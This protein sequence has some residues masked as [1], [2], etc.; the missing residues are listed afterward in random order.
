MKA[1]LFIFTARKGKPEFAELS[2]IRFR[3]HLTDHEGK[4]YEIRLRET[5]R[6]LQQ[7]RYYWLYLEII[8]SE[9]GHTADELHEYFR[10]TLLPPK[11]I[12]VMGKDIRLP[13]STTELSKHEMGEYLERICSQVSIPLPDPEEA[14]FITNY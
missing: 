11:F 6:T 5:K 8:A 2:E 1:P 10:R 7:N 13:R 14:G 12:T 4:T 3:Q 9:T